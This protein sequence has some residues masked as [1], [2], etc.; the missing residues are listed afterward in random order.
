MFR[1]NIK[2]AYAELSPSFQRLADFLVDYPYEAAF[3]TATQLGKQLD[4]DTATVVRFAQRLGYPGYPELLGEVQA[5]VKTQLA[6]YFEPVAGDGDLVEMFRTSLR[7]DLVSLQQFDLTLERQTIERL[8]EML[9]RAGQIVVLGEGMSG[10]LAQQMAR[11][12]HSVHY[13][14]SSLPPDALSVA[15]QFSMLKP[16]DLVIGV[17]TTRDCPDVTSAV[18]VAQSRGLP[19]VVVAGATSWPIALA[20]DLVV[21]CP[22]TGPAKMTSFTVF[23]AMMSALLQVLFLKRRDISIEPLMAFEDI[24]RRLMEARSHLDQPTAFTVTS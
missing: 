4:V 1:E 6:Q 24:L 20:A 13:R 21:V 15:E 11:V 9:D 19:T 3:M 14:A 22:H 8:L 18:Q 7:Q 12:L 16:N 17:A 2:S 10:P 23:S 5:E